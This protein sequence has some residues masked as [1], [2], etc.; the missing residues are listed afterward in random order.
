MPAANWNGKFMAVGN[1]G[2]GGSIQGFGEMQTALRLG[3]AT[4]GNDTGHSAADGPNGMFALG[5]P[6]KIV[7]FAYRA[8][9][10]MTVTSKKLIDALLRQRAAV[11]LLQGLLDRRPPGRDGGAALSRGLRRH[12]RRRARQP[13]HPDAHGRRRRAASSWRGIPKAAI[14]PA[15]AEMVNKA[16]MNTCDTLKEGFLNNPRACTFDFSKLA[17]QRA[18]TPTRCLTAPQL[19]T[20][21]TFY[22]GVEE[23][24]GRADLL[25]PGA[26]QPAA[27][28]ARHQPAAARRRL[29][30]RAHLGLPER[31]LRLEDVRPR[32]RHADHQQQGRLRGRGRSGPV[33]VQ[34][35]RRQAAALRRLGRHA[36]SRPRTRCSTTRAS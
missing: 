18:P 27:G 13:P 33:E 25:G 30:H 7:D 22:G 9:H 5:H 26:R 15:K 12:H 35:A 6:E 8:M 31:Q 1:G 14:P 10:E 17:V 4:A 21:E 3:Y 11:L 29:R 34:G 19:K 28:A 2:F 16:V 23:Q 20:V 36:A 32:S 24:Q